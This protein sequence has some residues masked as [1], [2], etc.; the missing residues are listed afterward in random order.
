MKRP[1]PWFGVVLGIVVIGL[2]LVSVGE[3]PAEE[4]LCD[5]LKDATPGLWGICH[6]Y[7]EAKDCDLDGSMSCDRII[8]SYASLR[9]VDDPALPCGQPL[10]CPC[11]NNYSQE[12]LV[13]LLNDLTGTEASHIDDRCEEVDE[14]GQMYTFIEYGNDQINFIAGDFGFEGLSCNLHH[15]GFDIDVF[16]DDSSDGLT[17]GEANTCRIEAA[18][19]IPLIDWCPQPE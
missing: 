18:A 10:A 19:L 17:S 4:G 7:C 3:T 12:E 1:L 5:E 15:V 9:T 14:T 11:W 16:L 2:T 8:A 6:A 13:A